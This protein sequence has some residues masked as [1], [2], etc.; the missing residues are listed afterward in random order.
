M[1]KKIKPK[2]ILFVVSGAKFFLSHRLTL[3][4]AAQS[5]GFDVHVATPPSDLNTRIVQSGLSHHTISLDRGGI[6]PFR[7]IMTVCSLWRLYRRLKPDLVHH[8]T[9]KPILYGGLVSRWLDIPAIVHAFTGLG[10]LFISEKKWVSAV[11]QIVYGIYKWAF[12]HRN[13]RF[14]FQNT[15]D[16]NQLVKRNIIRP[17]SCV[18]LPGSGVSMTAFIPTDETSETPRVILA[19]RLLWDKGIEEFVEAAQ[20]LKEKNTP[21]RFILVG[22]FDEANPTSIPPESLDYWVQSEIIE[23]WGERNDM[24]NVM[25]QAHIVCLPS[26]REGLPRVLVEAAASARAIVAT[27][28]SG[29]RAVVENGVNGLL[30]P[31]KNSSRLCE[32]LEHLISHPQLRQK[33]GRAGRKKVENDY[34]LQNIIHRTLTIYHELLGTA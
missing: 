13:I 28:I 9:I 1:D 2:K 20:R 12:G 10:F 33:M 19:S 21:A 8:V 14:I 24:P 29:C 15:E 3:A 34:E 31:V 6:N 25:Q 7:D 17:E 4:K 22:G 16:C 18:L 27:D 5:A 30:V 23:W 32:A 26:Y 11:R